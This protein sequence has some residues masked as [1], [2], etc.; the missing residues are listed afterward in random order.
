MKKPNLKSVIIFP[1]IFVLAFG[2]VLPVRA[3]G[4]LVGGAAEDISGNASVF[5]FRK[6]RKAPHARKTFGKN[7]VS[8]RNRRQKAAQYA[9]I[10][11][12]LKTAL[13]KNRA[14]T[15]GANNSGT[16]ART[17]NSN[18]RTAPPSLKNVEPLLT[19]AD[20][21]LAQGDLPGAI[22]SYTKALAVSPKNARA[23]AGL[24]DALAAK[25]DRAAEAGNAAQAIANYEEALKHDR[26][27]TAAYAG[28]GAVY[29]TMDEREKAV[30]NFEKALQL[31]VS[32][33]DVYYPLGV[34]YYETK[35]YP[36]AEEYLNKALPARADDAETRN[37]V[38]LIY[39]NSKRDAE[40][41]KAFKFAAQLK[42]DYAEAYFNLG[43]SYDRLN[44]LDEA[45]GA[46]RKAI[47]I[48][49]NYA[50]AWH[51]LGVAY[52]NRERY[53]ES[54][55]AYKQAA[56]LN[57]DAETNL[58]LADSYRQLKQFDNANGAYE[59]AIA[60]NTGAPKE[61]RAEVFEKYG[62]CLG[63]ANRWDDSVNALKETSELNPD[64]VTYANLSWTYSN[65]AKQ[66][67]KNKNEEE[68]RRK[69][70]ESK[71]AAQKAAELD[72]RNEAAKFN[73]GNAQAQLGEYDSAIENFRQATVMR[74][75]WAE[76]Y[77]G[78]GVAYRLSGDLN[79]AANAFNQ[80]LRI[81]N[82]FADAHLNM[83]IV[84][85]GRGNKREAK[86][87]Q[88]AVKRLNPAMA[89]ALNVFLGS[90]SPEQLKRRAINKI[91]G[92]NKVDEIKNKIRLP[93]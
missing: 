32:L 49:Q 71:T 18:R 1:L 24:S 38:G 55:D 73:L 7:N 76:G 45:I 66:D 79:N 34:L 30:A 47:E 29:D 39:A 59:K 35:N 2:G 23:S 51:N 56:A 65:S 48:N 89:V 3:D 21:A 60:Q 72:S 90:V 53:A 75:G 33:V 85:T 82:D 57:G 50:D 12:R 69:L 13:V 92:I 16:T 54:A 93:F 5:V 63:K 87:H 84:E 42:P 17:G 88:D 43:E 44:Q 81:N 26:E 8:A 70:E 86:K 61:E 41:V 62:Y 78:L 27:N 46:Y 9:A 11:A 25:G 67:A 20:A 22:Q 68:A 19:K 10:K 4:D 37:Y 74:S 15:R 77:N 36:K 91:P 40:A 6:G 14:K 83:A 58:A 28:L 64:S 52:Y 31:D 80:A